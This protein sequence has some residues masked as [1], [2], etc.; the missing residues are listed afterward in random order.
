MKFLLVSSLLFATTGFAQSIDLRTLKSLMT[1]RQ[2]TLER[3]NPGMSKTLLTKTR[4]PTELGP[5]ELSE[6]AVQTVLKIEG[7]KII[8]HSKESY[9]PAATPA[10]AGFETQNVSV[11]FFEAKPTLAADLADLDE[12]ASQIKS[13]S[14]AGEIISMALSVP[15]TREDGSQSVE[16]VSVKYDLSKPSFKNTLLIQD[17]VST[18][19]GQDMADIDV[20]SIDL[21]NVL[22]CE[23]AE[24]DQCSQ[25]DW[26]DILF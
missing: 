16:N 24:S 2:A 8:V 14:R 21:K 3:I 25:G 18:V 17:S 20:Y 23:S 13:I 22:F 5:C 11:I 7:D 15:V 10:C 26:S 12:T 1:Q 6:S 9:V 19:T 4:I